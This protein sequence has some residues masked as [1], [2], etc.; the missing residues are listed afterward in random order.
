M[1]ASVTITGT[2]QSPT[3]LTADNVTITATANNNNNAALAIPGIGTLTEILASLRPVLGAAVAQETTEITISGDTTINASGN[4]TIA[5]KSESTINLHVVS[6]ILVAAGVGVSEADSTV[7][8]DSGVTINS[9]GDVDI[10][11]ATTTGVTVSTTNIAIG[12][13]QDKVAGF[14]FV[15]NLSLA[16]AI[17]TTTLAQGAQINAPDGSVSVSSMTTKTISLS[18]SGGGSADT[19]NAVV[20]LNIS[21]TDAETNI[22]G[23]IKAGHDATIA[24]TSNT[25]ANETFAASDIGDAFLGG[26]AVLG[27]LG[28]SSSTGQA[29]TARSSILPQGAGG[30]AVHVLAR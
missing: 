14:D 2:D 15:V 18:A 4:V 28:L 9:G 24:A 13:L 7:R 19:V 25:P 3:I 21:T 16:T 20:A 22:A 30:I 12:A 8:I 17:A 23:T 10:S 6:V 27:G 11:S 29:L 5:G 1:D 26:I